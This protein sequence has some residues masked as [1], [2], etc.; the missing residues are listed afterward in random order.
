M[1]VIQSRNQREGYYAGYYRPRLSRENRRHRRWSEFAMAEFYPPIHGSY[2]KRVDEEYNPYK[3]KKK[4]FRET[5]LKK[6]LAMGR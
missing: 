4:T 6:L 5:K 2:W 3:W 1:K